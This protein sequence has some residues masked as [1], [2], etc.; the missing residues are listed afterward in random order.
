MS[1]SEPYRYPL[2]SVIVPAY[3]HERYVAAALDSVRDEGYPNLEIVLIDDGSTDGTWDI[4]QAWQRANASQ[5]PMRLQRQENAG[6]TTTL[7][8]LLDM[9][10]GE[11][12]TM[13]ASDDR[14]VTGGIEARV[15]FLQRHPTRHAVIGNARVIDGDGRVLR[16]KAV[17]DGNDSATRRLARD[18]AGQIIENFAIPGPVLLYRARA[19]LAIGGYLEGQQLEDWDLYLRLAAR[20]WLGFVDRPVADYREHE[21]N[22]VRRPELRGSL[23]RELARTA[24]RRRK[25]FRGRLYVALLHEAA[26]FGW[27]AAQVEHRWTAA[28][29]WFLASRVLKLAS[30]AIP[31]RPSDLPLAYAVPV[32]TDPSTGPK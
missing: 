25:L 4:V 26:T 21:A 9:A 23:A 18:P 5:V 28:T 15:R 24:F 13:L 31:R 17:A 6:L 16:Q 19:V 2:V 30:L 22:T 8:R 10:A 20:D 7:N 12:V 1:S 29:A 3:D 32:Q 11:Y 27:R 14:L